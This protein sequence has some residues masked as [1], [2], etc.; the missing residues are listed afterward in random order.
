MF[1]FSNPILTY[2]IYHYEGH[3]VKNLE[4]LEGEPFGDVPVGV[5]QEKL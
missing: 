4:G 1:S 3:H 2:I 5:C